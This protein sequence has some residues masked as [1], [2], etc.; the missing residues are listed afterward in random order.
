MESPYLPCQP[1]N[2][3]DPKGDGTGGC[4]IHGLIDAYRTHDQNGRKPPDV[5]KSRRRFLS[6]SS[7][8][9]LRPSELSRKGLVIAMEMGNVANTIGSQFLITLGDD[10]GL[11]DTVPDELTAAMNPE[12]A[13]NH[14]RYLSLGRVVED[15]GGV[16]DKLSRLY[17]D[18]DGRP[19][20]DVR[21]ERAL[22][23]HDPYDD[24]DG[25]D[26]LLSKRGVSVTP[27]NEEYADLKEGRP[28]PPS[29]P[30]HVRPPEETVP[31]RILADDT[32]LFA[33]T[34]WDE[35]DDDDE[36]EDPAEKKRRLE[37]EAKQEEEHR[38]RQ[39]TSRAVMLEM[40]GDRPDAE[41]EAPDDVLFVCKLNPL[42]ND[43]DLEL[44]FARFDEG[45]KAEIIR[46]PD[47]GASLHYAFVEFR[48]K[49]ACNEAYLK[50]D[51]ALVDDRRIRV[52]FSQSVS[53]IW[54]RYNKRYRT[55]ADKRGMGMSFG[56][57]RGGRGSGGGG[58]RGGR[59]GR[60]GGGRGLGPGGR[61]PPRREDG[62]RPDHRGPDRRGDERRPD[63][64]D[65]RR[66]DHRGGP[67]NRRMDGRFDPP[68]GDRRPDRRDGRRDDR[69]G[70]DRGGPVRGRGDRD[71]GG[72]RGY[73][74][75]GRAPRPPGGGESRRDRDRDPRQPRNGGGRD[76]GSRRPGDDRR[77]DSR[78][79]EGDRDDRRRER[80]R[81]D[82]R[83]REDGRREGDRRHRDRD[84]E[85][86]RSASGERR[87]R[88]SRS[89]SDGRD[90]GRR[91]E[92]RMDR[93]RSESTTSSRERRRERRHGSRKSKKHRR[94]HGGGSSRRH[95]SRS[96]SRSRDGG[97][98]SRK[99]DKKRR[100]RSPSR[101]RSRY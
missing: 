16:L 79:H 42:T 62:G 88:R 90:E 101:D 54:D 86:S 1:T 2:E 67:D 6:S 29:S 9:L 89:R 37:L 24:P 78:R 28:V 47:T 87:R 71:G 53:H 38:K 40:L 31:V 27:T 34:G 13:G 30:V 12:D 4:S 56:P 26:E 50:M 45:A 52:D 81:D 51:N 99:H 96:R 57:G 98:G 70:D 8:R 48:S 91:R 43:E 36:D 92:R 66:P 44:I 59:G 22:V 73:D 46:D 23:V 64:R 94:K 63:H 17:C 60:G 68:A 72:D 41:V 55:G 74:D 77:D 95:D 65:G 100:R 21:V 83:R 39:D 19:F 49:E 3:I 80:D 5:T 75:F 7:G 93:S 33:T 20:A 58:G 85:R 10:N 84:R 32:T 25:M 18:D 15:E 97:S 11:A 82:D 69:R 14:P 76:E 61:G 35:N